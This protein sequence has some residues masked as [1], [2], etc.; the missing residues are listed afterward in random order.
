MLVQKATKCKQVMLQEYIVTVCAFTYRVPAIE[1]KTVS[2]LRLKKVTNSPRQVFCS[3]KQGEKIQSCIVEDSRGSGRAVDY[4][5][6]PT[7]RR[8]ESHRCRK[9]YAFLKS[10]EKMHGEGSQLE[11][12]QHLFSIGGMP[13]R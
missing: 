5:V 10:Q 6:Q 8:S 11:R 4:R 1:E 13:S 12:N 2:P 3:R 9:Q 7:E